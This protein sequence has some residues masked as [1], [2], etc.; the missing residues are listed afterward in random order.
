MLQNAH[1]LNIPTEE[2][3][4]SMTRTHKR[5]IMHDHS[6]VWTHLFIISLL[7]STLEILRHQI[8]DLN[9]WINVAEE[10]NAF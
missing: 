4:S 7:L 9:I 5:E 1:H 8:Y 6:K 3:I 10:N 2:N